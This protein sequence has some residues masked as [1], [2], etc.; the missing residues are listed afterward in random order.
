MAKLSI[1]KLSHP[2][3]EALSV[4]HHLLGEAL[5]EGPKSPP[6]VAAKAEPEPK[7][8]AKTPRKT[9]AKQPAPAKTE[10]AP[11]TKKQQKVADYI[12]KQERSTT[13]LASQRLRVPRSGNHAEAAGGQEHRG[14]FAE[15]RHQGNQGG[16]RRTGRIALNAYR[17]CGQHLRGPCA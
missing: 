7:P 13:R 8:P 15:R 6:K 10:A 17:I 4:I 12:S 9:P 11:L 5:S 1:K 16:D 14:S 3:I 2:A